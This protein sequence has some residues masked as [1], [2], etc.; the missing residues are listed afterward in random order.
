MFRTVLILRSDYF[1]Q[2]VFVVQD[3]STCDA[4][5]QVLKICYQKFALIK[6]LRLTMKSVTGMLLKGFGR[7][8]SSEMLF[9]IKQLNNSGC[10]TPRIKALRSF[11]ASVIYKYTGCKYTGCHTPNHLNIQH[12]RSKYLPPHVGGS[13]LYLRR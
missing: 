4:T 5:T 3:L 11:A 10:A 1:H 6:V 7:L 13:L 2:Q 8:K 12:H 9:R